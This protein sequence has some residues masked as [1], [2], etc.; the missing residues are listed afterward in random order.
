MFIK[1]KINKPVTVIFTNKEKLQELCGDKPIAEIIELIRND[2]EHSMDMFS[3]DF[4]MSP[5]CREMPKDKELI[6]LSD[7]DIFNKYDEKVVR[8]ILEY[9]QLYPKYVM[10]SNKPDIDFKFRTLKHY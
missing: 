2:P 7:Y 5:Y 1:Q 6:L 8:F 3:E 9:M 10:E 4:Y